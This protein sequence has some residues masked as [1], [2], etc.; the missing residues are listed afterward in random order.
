MSRTVTLKHYNIDLVIK[1][2]MF[3]IQDGSHRIVKP[4]YIRFF[5]LGKFAVKL[6][7]T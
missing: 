3:Y 4:L 2:A 5:G 1:G 7:K 6:I